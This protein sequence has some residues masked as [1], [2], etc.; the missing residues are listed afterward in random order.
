MYDF[1]PQKDYYSV[2]GVSEN[3][4]ED[5]IKKAYRKLAMQYHPDRNKG[6]KAAEEKFKE[7][8]AANDVIGDSQ[9]RGQYD[10]M[11]RGGFG[12]GFGNGG[13][14]G[15]STDGATFQFGGGDIGDIFGDILGGFFGGG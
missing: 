13:F 9:K 3:A 5:E 2:L 15:F 12:G 1:D 4:T 11:R 10:A 6:D 7:I 8:N 14:G